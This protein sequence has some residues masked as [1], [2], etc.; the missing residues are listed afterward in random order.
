MAVTAPLDRERLSRLLHKYDT[1]AALRRAR[2]QGAPL[3]EKKVFR[4][5]A[6]EMPGALHE[7]DRL[8]L[9][10]IEARR[11][12]LREAL[13]GALQDAPPAPWMRAMSDYHAL[14][15]AALFVKVRVPRAQPLTD[16]LA[17]TLA[18]KASHHAKIPVD[19]AFVRS[20]AR[21]PGGRIGAVVLAET[22]ARAGQPSSAVLKAIFPTRRDLPIKPERP[23]SGA[24]YS[25]EDLQPSNSAQDSAPQSDTAA[26]DHDSV[27][28]N[29]PDFG[30]DG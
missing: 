4:D 8:P 13:E 29:V 22:A 19:A 16:E 18:D 1:L 9:D 15:R 20:V 14:Y 12:A 26:R 21:P 17:A 2:S 7:L 11:T 25:T 10:V 5:L 6:S 28:D 24:P 23:D 27:K 3:P 30:E